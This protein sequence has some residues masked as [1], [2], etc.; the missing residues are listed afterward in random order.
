M[1]L[2]RRHYVLAP[3]QRAAILMVTH[4]LLVLICTMLRA[5]WDT[6]FTEAG[7]VANAAQ[8]SGVARSARPPMPSSASSEPAERGGFGRRAPCFSITRALRRFGI[9]FAGWKHSRS[10]KNNMSCRRESARGRERDACVETLGTMLNGEVRKLF[11]TTCYG[12][13]DSCVK[14]VS[15]TILIIEGNCVDVTK[16]A[17]KQNR[18]ALER[19]VVSYLRGVASSVEHVLQRSRQGQG[20]FVLATVVIADANCWI[21]FPKDLKFPSVSKQIQ[22]RRA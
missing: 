22:V 5:L 11:S 4:G 8:D 1:L 6:D 10:S 21:S 18:R 9:N 3:V 20:G 15:S 16:N 17:K 13:G 7:H 2:L 12:F 19:G 14:E